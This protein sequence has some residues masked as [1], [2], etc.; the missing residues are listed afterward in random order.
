MHIFKTLEIVLMWFASK[1]H[2]NHKA[3]FLDILSVIFFSYWMCLQN[4]IF[5]FI[6]HTLQTKLRCGCL[7]FFSGGPWRRWFKQ[8]E[9]R[10]WCDWNSYKQLSW[11][12]GNCRTSR[13]WSYQYR[14]CRNIYSDWKGDSL[15]LITSMSFACYGLF[16]MFIS[17]LIM[18]YLI[19][20]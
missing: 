8:Q 19:S 9:W 1:T 10:C 16:I 7:I 2:Y 17:N 20:I 6:C 4:S 5:V 12:K 15:G 18:F 3:R 14:R 11:E 13:C